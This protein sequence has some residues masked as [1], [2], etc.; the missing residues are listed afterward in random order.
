MA[1]I[2]AEGIITKEVKYG[3]TSRILTILTREHGKVSAIAQGV[4]TNKSGLLAATQLF[5]LNKFS[6]FRT[7]GQSLFK[8]NEARIIEPFKNL[9]QSL[10]NM[11]YA[12]YFAD[13]GNLVMREEDEDEDFLILLLNALYM[14]DR[15][16][17]GREKIKAVFEFRCAAAEGFTPDFLTCRVCGS[18]NVK[19]ADFLK[20]CAYCEKHGG[21]YA[22]NKTIASV[23][24]YIAGAEKDKIFSFDVGADT[25]NYLSKMGEEYLKVHLEHEFRTLKYLHSVIGLEK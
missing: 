15:G 17:C 2:E 22:I 4:R 9:R 11:A 1:L 18:G 8:I 16:K 6:L 12:A 20:G 5:C 13:V 19:F 7:R 3:E 10:E 21:G 23:I 25:L 14:L 24:S